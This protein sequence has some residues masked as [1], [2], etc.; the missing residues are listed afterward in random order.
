MTDHELPTSDWEHSHALTAGDVVDVEE[1][2]VAM[3]IAEV[4]DDGSVSTN[5]C[6]D[7]VDSEKKIAQEYS[8]EE[9]TNALADGL[10]VRTDGK[11]HELAT[12]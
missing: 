4:H 12:Y 9:I 7:G 1:F 3:E 10:W 2:G 6:P 5:L 8:E 11:S